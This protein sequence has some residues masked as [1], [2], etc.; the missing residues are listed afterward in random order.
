MV[1]VVHPYLQALVVTA[2][3]YLRLLL[4]LLLGRIRP[5]SRIATA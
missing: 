1:K 4:L 2:G 3:N 5:Q